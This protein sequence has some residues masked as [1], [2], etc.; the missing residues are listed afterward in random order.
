V[1][2]CKCATADQRLAWMG[3]YSFHP[4]PF[5]QRP[6]RKCMD[7][8]VGPV[9]ASPFSCPTWASATTHDPLRRTLGH[10]AHEAQT[11]GMQGGVK[12]P[13]FCSHSAAWGSDAPWEQSHGGAL[14][15]IPRCQ[16]RVGAAGGAL[17]CS[18]AQP[19]RCSRLARLRWWLS[20]VTTRARAP[21]YP[22]LSTDGGGAATA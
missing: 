3:W 6:P 14:P 16:E 5:L 10:S 15:G 18:S 20:V 2:K 21:L 4:A 7:S 8:H 12:V 17:L 22:I 19:S 11:C 13:P 1:F 9:A